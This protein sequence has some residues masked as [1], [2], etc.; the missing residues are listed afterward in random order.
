MMQR[1]IDKILNLIL[2]YQNLVGFVLKT[3]LM[4]P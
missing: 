3:R 4:N 2:N 1:K